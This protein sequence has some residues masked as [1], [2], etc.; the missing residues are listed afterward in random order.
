MFYEEL[1][2]DD[3][4][5]LCK[6]AGN[7]KQAIFWCD[8]GS[9]MASENNEKSDDYSISDFISGLIDENHLQKLSGR[10]SMEYLLE[11]ASMYLLD[12][13]EVCVESVLKRID[14][15]E[16][17]NSEDYL[18]DENANLK[19][20]IINNSDSCLSMSDTS[21]C[22]SNSLLSKKLFLESQ[23]LYSIHKYE[24]CL[25]LIES[26]IDL[27]N[28]DTFTSSSIHTM[29]ADAFSSIGNIEYATMLYETALYESHYAIEALDYLLLLPY[30]SESTKYNLL[31]NILNSPINELDK[32]WLKNYINPFILLLEKSDK[33]SHLFKSASPSLSP[34]KK[35]EKRLL[36]TSPINVT[37]RI[38]IDNPDK[39][40]FK[41]NYISGEIENK[42]TH[43]DLTIIEKMTNGANT[44][45]G[46][47]LVTMYM[48]R[49]LCHNNNSCAYLL[50]CSVWIK[51]F[52]EDYD[53]KQSC[54]NFGEFDSFSCLNSHIFNDSYK[55]FK[56]STPDFCEFINMFSLCIVC[57]LYSE[58]SICQSTPVIEMREYIYLLELFI[59]ILKHYGG[60]VDTLKKGSIDGSLIFSSKLF[61]SKLYGKNS[62]EICCGINFNGNNLG[63]D[64][65]YEN[66]CNESSGNNS[67]YKKMFPYNVIVSSYFFVKG[68]FLF[69]SAFNRMH[70]N[71]EN[72]IQTMRSLLRTSMY[73][74]KRSI[75][76]N[77]LL[78]PA[79]YL[80]G[81]IYSILGQ[82]DDAIVILRRIIRLFP[83]TNLSISSATSLL[84]QRVQ[85]ERELR[86][87]DLIV[88]C[89]GWASKG[90]N[91]NKDNPSIYNTLGICAYYEKKYDIAIG[92]FQKAFYYLSDEN[93]E[94]DDVSSKYTMARYGNIYPNY[95]TSLFLFNPLPYIIS[96]NLALSYL[97]G[98]HYENAVDCLLILFSSK[99]YLHKTI[100]EPTILQYIYIILGMSYH[101]L[102]N[103]REASNYYELFLS[104]PI[105]DVILNEA[106]LDSGVPDSFNLTKI[107]GSDVVQMLVT[108]EKNRFI[109]KVFIKNIAE[110]YNSIIQI[111]A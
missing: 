1:G 28:F 6:E 75:N 94:V 64:L 41:N 15:N 26:S 4:I 33:A 106:E 97:M 82:W 100:F 3:Y 21:N 77:Y 79:Y 95:N 19:I 101:L 7:Y 69:A 51:L 99:K 16:L 18:N 56:Y 73:F 59:Q 81:N 31:N 107:P 70:S 45:L 42:K 88:Q 109:S 25:S 85:F 61:N 111:K 93:Y 86:T 34:V 90:L 9:A 84:L 43:Q 102:G 35:R 76:F 83:S 46:L 11:I 37:T 96:V 62:D 103:I 68:C 104:L 63:N 65:I 54:D 89:I 10:K 12:G 66:D 71:E 24:E 78:L 44:G 53:I 98:G 57:K 20:G 38:S 80:W 72:T 13:K 49:F 29:A 52:K 17:E 27:S 30:C 23:Y 36:P 58:V 40:A 74:L 5:E 108:N 50:G 22:D 48:Y 92:Y 47:K 110:L 32:L 87:N 55:T 60:E 105:D 67:W 2:V 14:T 91:I 39:I 8:V